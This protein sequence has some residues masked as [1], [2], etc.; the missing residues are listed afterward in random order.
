MSPRLDLGV[1][2]SL[3]LRKRSL[4]ASLAFSLAGFKSFG[5]LVEALGLLV[6]VVVFFHLG[7]T[8]CQSYP[9][10]LVAIKA[11]ISAY[12]G[13]LLFPYLAATLGFIASYILPLG[14]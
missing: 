14:T 1:L 9:P 13:A 2:S 5:D 6:L 12:A 8:T 10:S 7:T 4:R 3:F 11:A